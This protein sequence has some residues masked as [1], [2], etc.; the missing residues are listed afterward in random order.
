MPV[1]S[2]RLARVFREYEPLFY[3]LFRRA[4]RNIR[5]E[6]DDKALRR[7]LREYESEPALA[8]QQ[9]VQ[10]VPFDVGR[11]YLRG[12]L[13]VLYTRI[14][15]DSGVAATR[16][17][18]A[19]LSRKRVRKATHL[20]DPTIH[21]RFDATTPEAIE[22]IRTHVGELITEWGET[23]EEGLRQLVELAFRA[24][25]HPRNLA[26]L[27]RES[28]IGLHERYA[29]AVER[30]RRRLENDAML[31]LTD[32]VITQRTRRYAEKL[33]RARAK[34]IA[35]TETL[36]TN[37]EAQAQ[38]WDQAT[39]EGLLTGEEYVEWIASGLDGK[40]CKICGPLD[41]ERIKLSEYR[42]GR[43]F[44]GLYRVPQD[45]HPNCMCTIGL[46]VEY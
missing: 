23:S 15:D 28:G 12:A 11:R 18:A 4:T 8:G 13:P 2:R 42:A 27:I 41:G 29:N 20:P 22:W 43:R 40:M 25:I 9:I 36:R 26:P 16:D 39:D 38:L 46:I 35:R 21:I 6:I 3:Q 17:L 34:M 7:I 32:E 5:K 30:Y 19:M 37:N 10:A 33:E 45:T 1:Q 14:M 24:G 31:D 44:A